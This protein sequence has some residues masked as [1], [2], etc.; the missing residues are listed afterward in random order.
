MK[1]KQRYSSEPRN[2]EESKR[3]LTTRES[4]ELILQEKINTL[5]RKLDDSTSERDLLL[6][7]VSEL[8]KLVEKHKSKSKELSSDYSRASD[9]YSLSLIHI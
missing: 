2:F 1:P 7:K 5:E 4:K 8:N 6:E 9:A 3:E